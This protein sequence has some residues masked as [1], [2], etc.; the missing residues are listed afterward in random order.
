MSAVIFSQQV[1]NMADEYCTLFFAN[2]GF[3]LSLSFPVSCEK[4]ECII[5]ALALGQ[6]N[7]TVAAVHI[8]PLH[9]SMT[10]AHTTFA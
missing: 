8:N 10:F 7:S 6:Q 3:S 9:G 4:I 5:L 1:C 2:E